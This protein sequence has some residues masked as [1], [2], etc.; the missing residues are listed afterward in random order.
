MSKASKGKASQ[1][2]NA[3]HSDDEKYYSESE[4]EGVEDYKKGGYH[5]VKEGETFK[6]GRYAV[7]QKLGWGHFSTVWLAWDKQEKVR[8]YRWQGAGETR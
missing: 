3:E 1:T 5:P 8:G 2:R 6:A 7:L 4:E